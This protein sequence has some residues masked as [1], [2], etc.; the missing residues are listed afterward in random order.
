MRVAKTSA[1]TVPR[2]KLA[3]KTPPPAAE[4]VASEAVK[5]V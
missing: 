5:A 4:P 3:M 2:P 1:G